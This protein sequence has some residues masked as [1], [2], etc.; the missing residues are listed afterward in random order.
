MDAVAT[1]DEGTHSTAIFLVTR[2]GQGGPRT[3][4]D[5]TRA[6]ELVEPGMATTL[7]D[8]DIHAANTLAD[9]L[10]VSPADNATVTVDD[11]SRSLFRRCPG[12][13]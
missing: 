8:P 9:P 11:G 7:S 2:R 10:R 5:R 6:L 12:R 4:G 3:G 1:Y 13:H